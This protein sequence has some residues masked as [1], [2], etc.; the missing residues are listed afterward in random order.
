MQSKSC[1]AIDSIF[2][3]NSRLHSSYTSPLINGLPDH[4]AQFLTINYIYAAR[5]NIPSKQRTRLIN[6]DTLTN[7]QTLL[8]EETWESVYQSQDANCMFN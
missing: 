8:K 1:T 5:N 7:F 4:D 2:V 3:N 6:S